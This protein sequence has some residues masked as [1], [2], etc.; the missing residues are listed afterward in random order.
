MRSNYLKTLKTAVLAISVLLLG[1]S[2]SFAQQ[3][4]L[5]AGAANAPLPDGSSVPMWGY[6]CSGAVVAPVTC[7]ALNPLAAPGWSPIVITTPPGSLTINLTNNLTFASGAN[8]IPTS[9]VIVGQLGGGLGK[10]ATK[11][12]SPQHLQQGATWPIAGDNSGAVFNPPPQQDR[13]QSFSTEVLVGTPQNLT[14]SNLRP[15]TY[16]I[17]SGTHPSIQGPMGLY[18][19]LV[20]TTVPN[21]TTAGQ[22]YPGVSYG[23][24]VPLLM[25]EIDP[26]QNAA[27]QAAVVTAGFSET[28]THTMA[29]GVSVAVTA[30]GSGY[31]APPAVSFAGGGG[32][33]AAATAVIDTT[34]GSPTFG[35]VIAINVTTR[36]TGY[37]SN[38]SVILSGGGGT[39]AAASATLVL[40]GGAPCGTAAACYPPAVNYTPL[41]YLIN[42]Q[43]F[44]K[45]NAIGSQFAA[46]PTSG[47]TGGVLVRMVNAGLRM[48]VPSI[49]GSVTTPA[50]VPAGV[51]AAALGN[52]VVDRNRCS[53]A[54][55]GL[56]G[57]RKDYPPRRFR[58]RQHSI[59]EA[60]MFL[61]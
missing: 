44:N 4:F 13:V 19:I 57:T 20:V 47:V 33:G 56:T 5:T 42:G 34:S 9:L 11:A 54:R 6:T 39:G 40:V 2:V 32:S 45:T 31:T 10:T 60:L 46:S 21:G 14:W 22:A 17:E 51:T 41:Y 48:H 8:N 37:T 49:V 61:S 30:G 7:A 24:E 16:L 58:A 53:C 35:Q 26:A 25:S 38:P 12:P 55:S 52:G 29:D 50:V 1:A 43:A 28:A 59:L 27:V 23:A 15:G 36:G 18:G 3:V